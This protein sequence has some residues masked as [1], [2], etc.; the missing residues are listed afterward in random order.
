[1]NTTIVVAVGFTV[2][3]LSLG[4][5][6]IRSYGQR[7]FQRGSEYGSGT[8]SLL[9]IQRLERQ[10]EHSARI[11]GVAWEQS[12]KWYH[13]VIKLNKA[14]RR[15]RRRLIR[16]RA[17]HEHRASR[18][19]IQAEAS[20]ETPEQ[21]ASPKEGTESRLYFRRRTDPKLPPYEGREGKEEGTAYDER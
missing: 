7:E 2:V 3:G 8:L 10:V 1:M 6:A 13:E 11:A 18:Q 14:Q 16:W 20:V 5:M 9:K 12:Y 15:L 19:Q 21:G 4:L 17:E